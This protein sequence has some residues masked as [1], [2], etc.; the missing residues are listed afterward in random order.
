MGG[1]ACALCLRRRTASKDRG[2]EVGAAAIVGQGQPGKQPGQRRATQNACD[3]LE[4]L[5]ARGRRPNGFGYVIKNI[6]FHLA[7]FHDERDR[8]EPLSI[9]ET[10]T[11]EPSIACP[12]A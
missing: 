9:P 2:T 8:G 6:R 11:A 12:L 4:G 7:S 10:Y 5:A 3:A 1:I